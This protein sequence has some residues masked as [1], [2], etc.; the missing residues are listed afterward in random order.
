MKFIPILATTF[1]MGLAAENAAATV[2]AFDLQGVGG[3]GLLSTNE[4]TG[5]GAAAA[6][7]GIPGSGAEVGAG[8]SFDTATNLLTINVAWSNLQGALAGTVGSATGYHIH[9]PV[10]TSNPML[11]TAGVL[12]NISAGTVPGGI[13]TNTNLA[14][15]SGTV[16]GTIPLTQPQID[17]LF[18]QKFYFNVH[19]GTNSGGEIRGN[20]VP[21]PST[22][23]L[24]V[25]A[26][27]LATR[28]R[29]K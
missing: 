17:G 23:A 14:T 1:L 8:I 10:G 18:A 12:F 16:S 22:S 7:N 27:G 4:V 26:L 9:G 13:F 2:Y 25:L 3:V 24:G 11:G 21:E 15:G 20:L 29:R 6:I 28:R 5:A 19:S